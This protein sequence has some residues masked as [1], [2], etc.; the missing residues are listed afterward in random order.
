MKKHKWLILFLILFVF[1]AFFRFNRGIVQQDNYVGYA[2]TIPN[3]S[4][5]SF[6]DSRLLPGLPLLIYLIEHFTR[7]YFLAGYVVTFFSF[8]G[9]YYLLYKITGSKLSVLPLIFPPILLNLAVLI[10]TE[11]PFIFLAI[12]GYYLIKKKNYPLAF[13][14]FGLSVWFR[15]A[16]IALIFGVFIYFLVQKEFKKFLIYTPYFLIPILFLVIYN[17]HFFGAK[18]MF[19]QLS[20]YETLHPGR[21]SIGVV[22]LGQDLIRAVRWHWYRIFVSGLFYIVFFVIL[23]IK[24]INLKSLEFWII[25]SLYIFTLVVNLVPFLENLGRYLAP[26]V[27]FFWIAMHQKFTNEKLLYLLLP[28]SLFVVLL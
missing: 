21:I 24:S 14:F 15:I 2:Q 5:I 4:Q 17:V 22:Q 7:N 8:V 27:P 28:L 11:Y 26:A 18:N 9:S 16:G 19:Y 25:T 23:W 20:T 3:I 6:F 12:L 1:L 10:D 13:L